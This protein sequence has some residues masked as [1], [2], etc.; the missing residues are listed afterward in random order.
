MCEWDDFALSAARMRALL[1]EEQS[2]RISPFLLLSVP[3]ISAR[4]HRGCSELWVRDRVTASLP[5]RDRLAFRFDLAARE[6]LRIGYFSN[7]FHDHATSEL[8][9][10]TF[11]AHNRARCELH[12]FS[13]GADDGG[14]MRR[15]IGEAFD[16]FHDVSALS[17]SEVARAV[18]G[19]GIDILVDLKGYTLGARTGVMMLRPAPVQVNFLGYPG[20]LGAEICDYIITD[21]FMTP[22]AA[23]SDYSEAFAYMPNSYQPHGRTCAIGRKPTRAEAGLPE[24]GFV[25]CCFNQAYKFTPPVFDLWCRLL[26]AVPGSVLWLLGTE[27]AEGNLR[28]EALRRGVSPH[29]LVFAPN[30]EQSAHLGRLQLADLVLDTAPYGAHTTASDALW[31]GVPIVTCVGD[32]FAS[33][34]AGSLL[35]AIGLPELITD[36]E[37]DYLAVILALAADQGLLAASRAKLRRNRL[38]TPLFDV[39]AYTRA[40]EDLYET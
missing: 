25:F 33:R 3:G 34:V 23:A 22:M 5:E 28:G 26:N 20:T 7:D 2:G 40:L 1:A 18:H 15:R 17:D 6:K 27:Q 24:T 38:T 39:A 9:V 21:P 31:A 12:A 30:M 14:A 19:A 4:E 10:E 16:A 32:T 8:L 13:F 37:D 29:R 11:E 35:H 36:N